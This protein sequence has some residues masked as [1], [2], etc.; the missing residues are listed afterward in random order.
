MTLEALYFEKI[1]TFTQVIGG[2]NKSF[3]VEKRNEFPFGIVNK[4]NVHVMGP[5][6]Y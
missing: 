1:H 4:S 6:K 5:I 3:Y 2:K